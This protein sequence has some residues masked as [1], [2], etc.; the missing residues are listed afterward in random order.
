[1]DDEEKIPASVGILS[2]IF[3]WTPEQI[4]AAETEP[5]SNVIYLA[6]YR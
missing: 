5:E 4:A 2:P 3:D 1:M 6:D